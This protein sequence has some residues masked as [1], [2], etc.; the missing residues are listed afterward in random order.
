V[1]ERHELPRAGQSVTFNQFDGQHSQF[2][3]RK[4]EADFDKVGTA[5]EPFQVLGPPQGSAVIDGDGFKY[6]VAIEETAV[7]YRNYRFFR[8]NEFSIDQ[9]CHTCGRAIAFLART[10]GRQE[11][12]PALLL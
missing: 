1:R 4:G 6:P 2:I 8:W 5:S 11:V 3:G 9:C 12:V 10:L 7:D